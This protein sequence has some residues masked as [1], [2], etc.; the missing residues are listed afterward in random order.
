MMVDV[1]NVNNIRYGDK[2]KIF[3]PAYGS[4]FSKWPLLEYLIVHNSALE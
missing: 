1:R 4:H 3:F 2:L